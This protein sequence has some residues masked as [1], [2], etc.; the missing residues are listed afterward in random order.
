MAMPKI[1]SKKPLAFAISYKE[2]VKDNPTLNLSPEFHALRYGLLKEVLEC[3]ICGEII[4][5]R[6]VEDYMNHLITKHN[7]EFVERCERMFF[8][9]KLVPK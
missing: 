2:L 5:S 4:E 9:R 3:K 1:I 7:D 8:K 6:S